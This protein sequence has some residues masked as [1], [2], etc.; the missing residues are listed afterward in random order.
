MTE[1]TSVPTNPGED[2]DWDDEFSTF[3]GG[4]TLTNSKAELPISTA[5]PQPIP[6]PPPSPPESSD[7]EASTP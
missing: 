6:S 4:Q 7:T 1:S 2:G 5:T 3:R